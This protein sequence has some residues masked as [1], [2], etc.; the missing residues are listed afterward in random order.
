M[1]ER[2][3]S[4]RQLALDSIRECIGDDA[5]L[6]PQS[7]AFCACSATRVLQFYATGN[8]IPFCG[9]HRSAAV[10]LIVGELESEVLGEFLLPARVV[11]IKGR[12]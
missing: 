8:Y 1:A 4:H 12:G 6:Y 10:E 3:F 7:C 11:S 5:W 9:R 2:S